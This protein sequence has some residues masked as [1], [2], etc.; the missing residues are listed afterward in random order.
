MGLNLQPNR[1]NKMNN[2][3]YNHAV[4]SQHLVDLLAEYVQQVSHSKLCIVN[5]YK[6]YANCRVKFTYN[7]D[8]EWS[9]IRDGI[10]IYEAE[11]S[12]SRSKTI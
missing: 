6:D 5:C 11:L 3:T 8:L 2:Q 7:T 9:A 12:K 10:R 1:E 4:G